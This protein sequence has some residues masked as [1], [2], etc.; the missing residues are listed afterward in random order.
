[1][2][3]SSSVLEKPEEPT[4]LDQLYIGYYNSMRAVPGGRAIYTISNEQKAVETQRDKRID[5]IIDTIN[6]RK[7]TP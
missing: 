6:K 1:M 2:A 5:M 7:P 4:P 3:S